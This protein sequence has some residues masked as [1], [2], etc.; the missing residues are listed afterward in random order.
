MMP[1]LLFRTK[2]KVAVLG[3]RALG[4]TTP[5][6]LP[7]GIMLTAEQ[8]EEL[9]KDRVILI[10]LEVRA[11]FNVPVGDLE[12]VERHFVGPEEGE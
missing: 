3:R 9:T 8:Q 4:H 12:R 5:V 6:H 2:Q 7:L 1:S 10:D 11:G